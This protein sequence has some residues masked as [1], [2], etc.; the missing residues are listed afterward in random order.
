MCVNFQYITYDT[1]MIG[2]ISSTKGENVEK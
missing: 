2:S 1:S